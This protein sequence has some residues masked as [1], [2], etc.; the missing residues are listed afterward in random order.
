MHYMQAVEYANDKMYEKYG[1]ITEWTK[2]L[3]N[4]FTELVA[5]AMSKI[6]L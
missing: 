3:D 5:K 6:D 1:D 4:E 2:E